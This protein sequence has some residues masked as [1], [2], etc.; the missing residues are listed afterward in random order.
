M[1]GN[2]SEYYIATM[3][4]DISKLVNKKTWERVNFND[5]PPG[6]FGKPCRVL[7]GT[8]AFKFKRLLDGIHLKNKACYCVHGG[9]QTSGVE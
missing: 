9:I 4:K 8:W 2:E 1:H 5:I 7:K 6:P 3:K